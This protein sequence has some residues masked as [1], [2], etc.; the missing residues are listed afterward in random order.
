MCKTFFLLNRA[1]SEIMWK[2]IT[3]RNVTDDNNNTDHALCMPDNEGNNTDTNSEHL[4]LLAFPRQNWLRE[5]AS[6]VLYVYCLS[7]CSS[8][9]P[10]THKAAHYRS[11]DAM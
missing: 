10:R 5:R 3:A 4:I 9:R 8:F 2:N 6:V 7:C 1:V 11:T